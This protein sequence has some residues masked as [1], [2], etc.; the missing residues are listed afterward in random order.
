MASIKSKIVFVT[1]A[2]LVTL[3]MVI[4]CTA[5]IAFYHDKELIIVSNK[6]SITTFE[7]QINTEISALEKNALDLSLMGEI[8]YQQ[9]KY[10]KVGEFF[11]QN[12][13][14]NYPNSMGNGIYFLPYKIHNDQKIGCYLNR[15]ALNVCQ[16][17]YD[18]YDIHKL[19]LD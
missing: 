15:N 5:I 1:F 9:G 11:A 3:G 8:Y 2:L 19:F 12:I 10:Q 4:V 14:K 16:E 7:G 17:G 18:E 13:L 6:V